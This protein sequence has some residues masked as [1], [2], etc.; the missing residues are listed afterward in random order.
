[1][2]ITYAH[3]TFE[4]FKEN[5]APRM[6]QRELNIVTKLSKR[7][8]CSECAKNIN[9]TRQSLNR[10]TTGGKCITRTI[11][12]TPRFFKRVQQG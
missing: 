3:T 6:I 7:G 9:E 5:L 1:M 10:E 11:F 2:K 12:E 4:E 8:I